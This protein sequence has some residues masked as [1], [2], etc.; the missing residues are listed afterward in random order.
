MQLVSLAKREY[1]LELP[2]TEMILESFSET[3]P[4][5]VGTKMG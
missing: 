2:K 4:N 1:P 3:E 5:N